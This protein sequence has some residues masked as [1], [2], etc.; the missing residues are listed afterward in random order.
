[1][2]TLKKVMPLGV[3][4][5]TVRVTPYTSLAPVLQNDN[6]NGAWGA[7]LNEI[8][9]LQSGRRHGEVLLRRGGDHVQQRHRRHWL[10]GQQGGGRLGQ[11]AE[12]RW[13]AG[14]R[15]GAQLQPQSR[16]G[17]LWRRQSRPGFPVPRRTDRELG[18]RRGRAGAQ[19]ADH[20]R[21]D[22]LL[23]RAEVDQR[24]Q[25]PEGVQLPAGQHRHGRGRGRVGVAGV[26]P[27][28]ER[29][30][31]PGAGVRGLVSGQR[32]CAARAVRAG[33]S[34]QQRHPFSSATRSRA[35]WWQTWTETSASLRT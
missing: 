20:A 22:G 26:G 32:T 16:A 10:R 13:G 5:P 23:Q 12:R 25:L 17:Y 21:P 35:S 4:S 28:R 27:D 11:V 29:H 34:R 7:V 30:R 2:V 6:A 14:A 18:T 8:F 31:A 33:G 3:V 9:A 15:G 1:M 19:G 24:L